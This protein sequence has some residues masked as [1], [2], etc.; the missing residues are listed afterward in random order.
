MVPISPEI[1][2]INS[3]HGPKVTYAE[4]LY[5]VKIMKIQAIENLALGNFKVY[6]TEEILFLYSCM[7]RDQTFAA[8]S[9]FQLSGGI[10]RHSA[11]RSR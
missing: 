4:R 8:Y 3:S 9:N 10:F 2:I 6:G 11:T 5:G 1:K 7:L